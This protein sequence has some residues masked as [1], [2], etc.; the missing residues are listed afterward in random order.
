MIAAIKYGD[1]YIY[2]R[3]SCEYTFLH[4]FNH[5]FFNRR[6]KFTRNHTT[7]DLVLDLDSLAALI[8]AHLDHR[9]PVLTL[10]TRLADELALRL[11]LSNNALDP[12]LVHGPKLPGGAY[13]RPLMKTL[14]T[15][16]SRSPS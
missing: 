14:P 10:A 13:Y 8:R 7:N 9:M 2:D 5:T 3:I 6:N 1:F 4:S 15:R 16:G 12:R 11:G